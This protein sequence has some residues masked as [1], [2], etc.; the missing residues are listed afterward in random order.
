M[1]EETT[2]WVEPHGGNWVIRKGEVEPP[3]DTLTTKEEAE[4][5]AQELAAA[6]GARVE[7][8]E[9]GRW[10]PGA[11]VTGEGGRGPQVGPPG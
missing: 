6:T 11:G 9:E 3:L 1:V 10:S 5:R 7:V 2:L 8:R 4:R